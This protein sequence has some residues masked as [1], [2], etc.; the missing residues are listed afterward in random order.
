[1]PCRSAEAFGCSCR[2]WK[3]ACN[4]YSADGFVCST[5]PVR[6]DPASLEARACARARPKVAAIL[7]SGAA[8]A[9]AAMSFGGIWPPSAAHARLVQL[10]ATFARAALG[11]RP[12][13]APQFQTAG[14]ADSESMD[15]DEPAG[16][17][18]PGRPASSP[19]S[20][21][22]MAGPPLSVFGHPNDAAALQARAC[23][24]APEGRRH[25]AVGHRGRE[26]GA[27]L[28]GHDAAHARGLLA[29]PRRL[30]PPL[31]LHSGRRRILRPMPRPHAMHRETSVRP[32]PRPWHRF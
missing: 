6:P 25:L 8:D 30:P 2:S 23:T 9:N 17:C 16:Q 14:V 21:K 1:M 12:R 29:R 26:R 20:A 4:I 19:I 3:L 5:H 13:R 7:Q 10:K 32:L 11:T 28:R 18:R 31:P 27:V 15:E 24:R 22:N